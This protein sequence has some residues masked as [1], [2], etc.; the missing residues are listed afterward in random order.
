MTH[1]HDVD[2]DERS[3]LTEQDLAIAWLVGRYI[4]RREHDETRACTTCSPRPPNSAGT[5]S[6]SCAPCSRSTRPCAL[7]ATRQNASRPT[8]LTRVS[9]YD[10]SKEGSLMR[11][12][13]N[14]RHA[15]SL[16]SV[17]AS[18]TIPTVV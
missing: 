6:T 1:R 7:M 3:E 12:P 10:P 14:I 15:G 9:T 8:V 17:N 13:N 11:Q 5:P 4:E 2:H 16:D 18:K